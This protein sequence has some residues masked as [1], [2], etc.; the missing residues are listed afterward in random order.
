MLH[1]LFQI[2]TVKKGVT[3]KNEGCHIIILKKGGLHCLLKKCVSHG[4]M[5]KGA[6]QLDMFLLR[7]HIGHHALLQFRV[8]PQILSTTST[9][10]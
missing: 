6:L 3:M 8:I 7:I 5:R 1:N 9:C 2:I 10:T 4:L